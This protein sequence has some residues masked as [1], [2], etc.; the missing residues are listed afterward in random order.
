MGLKDIKFRVW[1]KETKTM[2]QVGQIHF[3]FEY[4]EFIFMQFTGLKDVNGTDIY[5]GDILKHKN[6]LDSVGRYA[7][8]FLIVSFSLKV[9]G[10][11]AEYIRQKKDIIGTSLY[12]TAK[13]SEIIGNVYENPELLEM[14]K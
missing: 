7:Y 3:G 13:S 11:I 6:G 10:F 5:E 1:S 2:E 8:E 12:H 4:A 9:P 14:N